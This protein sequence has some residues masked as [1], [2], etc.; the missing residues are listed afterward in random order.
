MIFVPKKGNE[1]H[2][3]HSFSNK[4]SLKSDSSLN[5]MLNIAC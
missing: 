2:E 4:S 3:Y 5:E 1:W